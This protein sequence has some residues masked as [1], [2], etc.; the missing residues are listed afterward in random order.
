M[1]NENNNI[2]ITIGGVEYTLSD[3]EVIRNAYNEILKLVNKVVY[4]Y[5]SKKY[6]K[7]ITFNPND[8]FGRKLKE[9][10]EKRGFTC[11]VLL[12]DK[13]AP[14]GGIKKQIYMFGFF[15]KALKLAA[16][17]KYVFLID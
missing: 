3:V 15:A 2:T 1:N 16:T 5:K 6:K 9:I 14:A 13:D 7:E 11:N 17:V 10:F 8:E 12:P 4:G